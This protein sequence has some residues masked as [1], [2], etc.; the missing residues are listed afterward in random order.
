MM[1]LSK[2]AGKTMPVEIKTSSKQYTYIVHKTK[3][4]VLFEKHYKLKLHWF[5]EKQN[6]GKA[7]KYSGIKWLTLFFF[8]EYLSK[9]QVLK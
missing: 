3:K 1:F 7:A 4:L 5:S 6:Q 2:L 8:P 9:V